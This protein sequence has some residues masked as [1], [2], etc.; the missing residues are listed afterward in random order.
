[1]TKIVQTVNTCRECPN[2]HYYSG[3]AYE[4]LK[5]QPS[6]L[7]ADMSIPSWCPLAD[8]SA[9]GVPE[10]DG[11]DEPSAAVA[12]GT[13]AFDRIAD[14]FIK[15]VQVRHTMRDEF[16]EALE[17]EAEEYRCTHGVGGNDAG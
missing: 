10:V 2:K 11:A 1:M 13:A 14:G 5:V 9:A 3:G 8:Y 4:C 17:I 6:R 16:I 12:I 15:S 7:N